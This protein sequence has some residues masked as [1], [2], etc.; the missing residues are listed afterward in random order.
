MGTRGIN[1]GAKDAVVGKSSA[2]FWRGMFQLPG[3]Y[4]VEADLSM[5]NM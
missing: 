4:P 1:G 3:K 2:T 5:L